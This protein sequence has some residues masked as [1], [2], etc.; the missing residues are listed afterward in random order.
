MLAQ[1]SAVVFALWLSVGLAVAQSMSREEALKQIQPLVAELSALRAVNAMN[2]SPEQAR[3]L[4]A[5]A[6]QGQFGTSIT[7]E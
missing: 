5:I 1:G 7:S 3:D 2:L 4:L 6:K